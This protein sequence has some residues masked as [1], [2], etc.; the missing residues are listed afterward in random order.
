MQVAEYDDDM[1]DSETAPLIR[2][3]VDAQLA[4]NVSLVARGSHKLDNAYTFPYT[5]QRHTSVNATVAWRTTEDLLLS[6]FG[7]TLAY[8]TTQGSRITALETRLD[9]Y[10]RVEAEHR[11]R[12]EARLSE[13]VHK[14]DRDREVV[15]TMA[16]DLRYTAETLRRLE[17]PKP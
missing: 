11:R 5:S 2:V 14:V 8:V 9:E 6:A 4:E 7:G 1:I 12:I 13:L 3:G 17:G 15:I 10:Q 16:A